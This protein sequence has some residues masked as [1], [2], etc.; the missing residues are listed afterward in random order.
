MANPPPDHNEFALAAEA[1]LDNMNGWVKWGE[2]EEGEEDLEMEEEEEDPE[3]EEKE[4]EMDSEIEEAAPMSPPPIPADLEPE[5][6]AATVSTGRLVPLTGRRPF[7]NTQVH[8]GSST[9]ATASHDPKDLA[10]SVVVDVS[11]PQTVVVPCRT[12]K[13]YTSGSNTILIAIQHHPQSIV[14]CMNVIL[15]NLSN[16][17]MKCNLITPNAT[18]REIL[19]VMTSSG[20]S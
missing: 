19:G 6:E 18:R 1:A 11:E 16:P 7:S 20:R 4:E 13:L 14:L 12:I 8:I 2:D 5:A 15:L 10:P 3:M 9:S 17:V